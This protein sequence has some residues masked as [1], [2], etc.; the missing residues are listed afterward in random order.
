MY[1]DQKRLFLLLKGEHSTCFLL[2]NELFISIVP[3]SSIS[4]I[5]VHLRISTTL[6]AMHHRLDLLEAFC[7][8][9][10]CF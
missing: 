3:H 1:E 4:Y 2:L 6:R 5:Q 10:H 9:S 8:F 7:Y